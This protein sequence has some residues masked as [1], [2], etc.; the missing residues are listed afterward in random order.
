MRALLGAGEG[1]KAGAQGTGPGCL[2]PMAR[3][4]CAWEMGQEPRVKADKSQLSQRL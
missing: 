2:G 3:T 4:H 1:G